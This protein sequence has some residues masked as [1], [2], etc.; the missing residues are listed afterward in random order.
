[1]KKIPA[2]VLLILFL[3]V[4][5]AGCNDLTFNPP[6]AE[7][8][9]NETTGSVRFIATEGTPADVTYHLTLG[10]TY[11]ELPVPTA[12]TGYQFS[13]WYTDAGGNGTR[14]SSIYITNTAQILFA[15]FTYI[16]YSI[17]YE[18]DGGTNGSNPGSYTVADSISLNNATRNTD[19]FMGWYESDNDFKTSSKRITGWSA[20][21]KIGNITLYARWPDTSATSY[22]ITYNLNGGTND[23]RNWNYYESDENVTLFSPSYDGLTFKGWYTTSTFDSGTEI[24][25]WSAG[26]KTGNVN[27][28]ARFGYD[29]TY[30][31]YNGAAF[32]G[33]GKDS[34]GKTL[35][36]YYIPADGLTLQTPVTT[37]GAIFSGWYTDAAC[38]Q[39][40]TA[41]AAGT[42]G[43]ITLYAKWTF[44]TTV[45]INI[46]S[47]DTAITMSATPITASTTE[48]AT[49]CT[50]T[51]SI[52]DGSSSLFGDSLL[53][54]AGITLYQGGSA[55]SYTNTTDGSSA[56]AITLPTWL[57]AG[58]YQLYLEATINAVDYSGYIDFTVTE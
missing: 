15:Y 31:D 45:T 42:T 38:T 34:S 23:G 12:P 16:S 36:N 8:I 28:Y 22:T 39:S 47:L 30:Y 32:S 43:N 58:T 57:P 14:C 48:I 17:A 50:I 4:L 54:S 20:G 56:P 7:E 40:I 9:Q 3:T 37:T 24:T 26:G 52:T 29:I 19:T 13:G 18:L 41:I 25:G 35:Q 51:M 53:T 27:V 55:T 2:G 49:G 10:T 44:I 21:E 33:T 46:P 5:L 11:T 1:M 6:L